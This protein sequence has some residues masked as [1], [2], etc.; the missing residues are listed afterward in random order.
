MPAAKALK[1]KID[2]PIILVGGIKSFYKIEEILESGSSDFVSMSRP[3][4]RQPD[5]PSLW[6]SGTGKDTAECVSCNG[7]M[8][9]GSEPLKCRAV[10]GS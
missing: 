1:E 6:L 3:L 7:C 2:I 4:I 10:Q 5:L 9:A 8:P